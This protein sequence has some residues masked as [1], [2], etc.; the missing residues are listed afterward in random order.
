MVKLSIRPSVVSATSHRPGK[1]KIS[2]LAF[3]KRHICFAPFSPVHSKTWVAGTR[4]RRRLNAS[5]KVAVV[6]TVSALALVHMGFQSLTLL[7]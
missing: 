7:R 4:Q 5:R 3:V 1:Q 6:A 2:E